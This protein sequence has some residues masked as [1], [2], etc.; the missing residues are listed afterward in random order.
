MK[1]RIIIPIMVLALVSM[2][3]S[4][5]FNV[6]RN[7]TGSLE[8]FQIEEKAPSNGE[9]SKVELQVGAAELTIKDGSSNLLEGEIR[10]NN[11]EWKPKVEKVGNKVVISQPRMEDMNFIPRGDSRNEWDLQIGSTPIDL[12]I[13]AGAY[14]GKIALSDY[15]IA[16][17]TVNDGASDS[18]ITFEEPNKVEM[19]ELVYKTG[20]SKVELFGLGNAN[21]EDLRFDS[22]AGSYTL[23]FSGKMTRDA[24]VSIKSGV[25]N[26]EIVIPEGL[27]SQVNVS[28]GLNNIDLEGTWT[29]AGNSYSTDGSG[30]ALT[31]N[32]DMGVGNVRLV[33]K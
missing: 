27:K 18:K 28:G 12:T 14:Q 29:S 23:D 32:I 5:S 16:N 31:I 6:P 26:I 1:I 25:S 13:Y 7:T 10:Y 4:I 33:S 2:A 3:C 22:G 17:L 24:S 9:V 19:G 8:T 20:A 21:F 30:P 15:S 11:P